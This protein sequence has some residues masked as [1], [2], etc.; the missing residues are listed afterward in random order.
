MWRGRPEPGQDDSG[1]AADLK[2]HLWEEG[3]ENVLTPPL[4]KRMLQCHG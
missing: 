3:G 4:Q 1:K 2:P